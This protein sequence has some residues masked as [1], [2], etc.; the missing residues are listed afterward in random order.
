MHHLQVQESK[1]IFNNETDREGCGICLKDD[2]V[3]INPCECPTKYHER[4]L[5]LYIRG[6]IRRG[7]R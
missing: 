3:L 7:L 1:I 5:L 4:C 6:V 2:N